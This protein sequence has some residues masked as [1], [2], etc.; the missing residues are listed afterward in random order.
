MIEIAE[1]RAGTQVL[2]TVPDCS[3]R[4]LPDNSPKCDA[5]KSLE[6]P[7]SDKSGS[8]YLS[9]SFPCMEC[10]LLLGSSI[11]ASIPQP[12]ELFKSITEVS[13][14]GDY[15]NYE[16]DSTSFRHEYRNTREYSLT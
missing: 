2:I 13:T 14:A 12:V 9:H 7:V 5:E 10:G 1:G 6:K 16:Y 15:R 4:I 11:P 8:R 3:L